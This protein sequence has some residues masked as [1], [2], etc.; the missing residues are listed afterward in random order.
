M[1]S[2]GKAIT[3][4]RLKPGI[5]TWR[6]KC[7]KDSERPLAPVSVRAK[8]GKAPSGTLLRQGRVVEWTAART[9]G[10]QHRAHDAARSVG[11]WRSVG[12]LLDPLQGQIGYDVFEAA[13][14][15]DCPVPSTAS[16][17]RPPSPANNMVNL[18]V[19]RGQVLAMNTRGSE[20]DRGNGGERTSS[21]HID[22]D[23][24]SLTS[25]TGKGAAWPQ[26]TGQLN[27]RPDNEQPT[28]VDECQHV[29]ALRLRALRPRWHGCEVVNLSWPRPSVGERS[30]HPGPA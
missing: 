29:G 2:V 17:A 18:R 4:L 12:R 28:H 22:A 20:Q 13:R 30:T 15:N 19:E 26:Q 10:D 9:S 1:S 3:S 23:S 27:R 6:S 8:H 5:H 25:W 16:R 14:P 21:I 11:T 24:Q 7:E